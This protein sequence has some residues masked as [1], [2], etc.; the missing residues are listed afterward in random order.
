MKPLLNSKTVCELLGGISPATLSRMI[1][2]GEIP[3]VLLRAGK[4]KKRV[5]FDEAVL[6]KWIISR[7]RGP[8]RF[9]RQMQVAH[10]V[11]TEP[12]NLANPLNLF[13]GHQSEEPAPQ[14]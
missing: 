14:S 9:N 6:E 7:S 13:N 3:Y 4:R 11:A 2:A 10:K 12:Q 8:R 1:S 5:A